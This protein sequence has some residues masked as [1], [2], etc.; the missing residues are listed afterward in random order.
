MKK[1]ILVAALAVCSSF[2]TAEEGNKASNKG[3]NLVCRDLGTTGS[4]IA[5]RRICLTREQWAEQR[6]AQRTEL[7]RMQNRA[8]ENELK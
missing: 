3:G 7:E 6:R 1:L 8:N 2:A 5:R 4:R